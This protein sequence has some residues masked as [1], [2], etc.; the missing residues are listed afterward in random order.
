MYCSSASVKTLT[1]RPRYRPK[2]VLFDGRNHEPL[3]EAAWAPAEVE[4]EIRAI[5]RDA[6]DAL[7]ADWWPGHPLDYDEG[8]PDVWHGIYMGAAGVLWALNYLGSR[9]DH[10][11]LAGRCSRAT[12]PARVREAER[13]DRRE[14][15][16]AA[17]VAAGA[18][19]A[20]ADRL[21]ELVAVPEDDTLE[22]MWGSPG[23]C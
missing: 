18:E 16:R 3:V 14:R 9:L 4:A 20:L 21:A 13:M 5:V 19:R 11:R 7:A 17:R 8:D 2:R 15:D 10:A 22:L 23:L 6:E 1:A 12:A